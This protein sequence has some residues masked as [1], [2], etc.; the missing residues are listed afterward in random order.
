MGDDF[1]DSFDAVIMVENVR[2]GPSRGGLSFDEGLAVK[3]GLNVRAAGSQIARGDPL[4]K[5]GRPLLPKDLAMLQMGGLA[6]VEV[7]RK[8]LVAF[9]PTGGEL[10]SPGPPPGR[11]QNIDTNSLLAARTMEEWGAQVWCWPIVP[12]DP[13]AL[14]EALDLALGRADVVILNGGSSKGGEDHNARL[15]ADRAEPLFRGVAAAPGKPM[16]VYLAGG[17]PSGDRLVVNLPGPMIAAYY[18]LEWCLRWIVARALGLA[19]GRRRKVKAVLA[20]PLDA[21]GSLS[22]L[23]NIRLEKAADGSWLAR[24]IDPRKARTC[25]GVD[26]N[27]QYMSVLGRGPLPAGEEIWVEVLRSEEVPEE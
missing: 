15:L 26:A 18:G 16:G 6:S 8:P 23:F 11:G 14:A 20:E 24:P 27:A 12:D 25:E 9:I 5:A 10:I 4:A 3:P 21:P 22:F 19:P 17:G 13:A 1:G 2:E 7:A